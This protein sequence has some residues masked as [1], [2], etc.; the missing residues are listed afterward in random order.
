MPLSAI[1]GGVSNIIGAGAGYAGQKSANKTNLQ[2]A[3][4]GREH[5]VNMWNQQN[6]YNTPEMQMQRMKEAGLNPNLVAGGTTQAGNA[7]Q[8]KAAQVPHVQNELAQ[9]AQ[10][11]L[12]PMIA[13]YQD[14]LVKRQTADNLKL[15]A[16]G[17]AQDNTTK[18]L[19]NRLLGIQLPWADKTLAQKYSIGENQRHG[20]QAQSQLL[21]DKYNQSLDFRKKHGDYRDNI[22]AESQIGVRQGQ[23]RAL[24]LENSLN[25]QLKPFGVNANDSLWE[26]KLIPVMETLINSFLP[27]MNKWRGK[28]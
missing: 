1:I 20:S 2:L 8:P 24:Q 15:Q 27:N 28:K 14:G 12:I 7:D 23:T 22:L 11:N 4:E 5:D 6:A 18:E 21:W 13:T 25:E 10:M 3:K 17:I 16:E 9:M 26:R 19:T